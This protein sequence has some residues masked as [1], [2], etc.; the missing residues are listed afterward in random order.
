MDDISSDWDPVRKKKGKKQE[1]EKKKKTTY[2]NSVLYLQL[3]SIEIYWM[4]K[5]N[6]L[7][8]N[9]E[10]YLGDLLPDEA[11]FLLL[12]GIILE[13]IFNLMLAMCQ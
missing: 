6:H 2:G 3:G 8:E 11:S 9:H 13:I 5:W 7:K 12:H 10:K 1:K 4:L